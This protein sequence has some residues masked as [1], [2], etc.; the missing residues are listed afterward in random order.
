MV[1]NSQKKQNEWY[2]QWSLVQDDSLFLFQE[3]IYP[4]KLDD[5]KNA[6][7]LECGC[8]GGQ[9]TSFIAPYAKAITSVDLNAVS[10]AKNRNK[11]FEN[12]AF[13]DEDILSMDLKKQFDIVF[14]IGVIHHTDDPDLAVENMIMHTKK[15]GKIIIWVYSKEG[16]FL[17]RALVEPFRKLFL[18]KISRK[19]LLLLSKFITLLMYFPIYTLYLFKLKFLPYY[20]YFQN[21]RRLTFYRNVLNVFDK[22]NAPQ[23]QFIDKER[24]ERWANG[25]FSNIH[26]SHYKGVSYRISFTKN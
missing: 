7:V 13:K 17:V 12:I 8:G 18:T 2:E 11:S 22:L 1:N 16:N 15:G 20:E 6:E 5:F 9:H 24:A 26:I 25:D 14:S 3:W 4:N 19:S 21:F 10:L 23:V